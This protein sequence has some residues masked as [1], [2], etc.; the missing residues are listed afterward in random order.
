MK[1]RN[2]FIANMSHEI[3]TPMNAIIGI[4]WA[5]R[6]HTADPT[7]LARL[8]QVNEATQQ[9]LAVINGLPDMARLESEQ[10][11]LEPRD[12][13]PA[14]LI[15]DLRRIRKI[16][17]SR[18]L[19][20]RPELH[21]LPPRCTATPSACARSSAISSTTRSSSTDGG[22]VLR[23]RRLPETARAGLRFEIEDSGPGLASDLL[24]ACSIPSSN[25]MPPRPTGSRPQ[26]GNLQ[27]TG[28]TDGG[29]SVVKTCPPVPVTTIAAAPSFCWK[30][31]L[32]APDPKTTARAASP[33]AGC[34]S[35]RCRRRS[36]GAS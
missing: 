24:P 28:R 3:R 12:F 6:Q 10:L 2:S 33:D 25:R 30:S 7:Q 35:A 16:A 13:S 11:Q 14:Q 5:L 19:T 34:A 9:L 32:P 8:H 21:D 17:E 20:L 29:A 36:R 1:A 15:D 26:S 31:C 18:S 4:T 22:V 27:T 23:S